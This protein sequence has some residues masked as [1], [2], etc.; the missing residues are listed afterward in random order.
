MMN[1]PV[2][3]VFMGT[4]DFSV[5]TLDA[6]CENGCNVQ[7]VFTQPDRPRGRGNKLQPSPVKKRAQELEIPVYQPTSLRKGEDAEQAFSVLK[8]LQPDLIVV[9]AYGQ[10][11]P[12]EILDLPKYGC[13]NL[14]ASLLPR[15]RGA[16]PIQRCILAGDE[17]TG[18]TSM[19]MAAGLDTG[20][21]LRVAETPIAPDETASTLHDRLSEL[22]AKVM[23]DTLQDILAGAL[24][25]VKQDDALACTADK[26]TKNMS[27]LDFNL[28]AQK[29]DRTIRA[30]T[31]FAMLGGK[32]VKLL[33]SICGG[34][35]SDAAPGEIVDAATMR[36]VCGDGKCVTPLVIQA[37]GS[38]AM[39]VKDYLRGH[40]VTLGERFS[41]VQNG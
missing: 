34:E 12:Q 23:L 29:I 2:S 41:E 18:V 16:G 14:H 19:Q 40:P 38:K 6:L 36:F 7:A 30:L 9:I 25:P 1:T 8:E 33:G 3:I 35:T 24:H 4:P 5:P 13:V 39:A 28:P 10:I 20:D 15:W 21:M 32:R 11:L 27:R 31:G 26:L 37:E 17:K 22:S